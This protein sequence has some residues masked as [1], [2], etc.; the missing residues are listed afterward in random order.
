MLQVASFKLPTQEKEANEF[1]RTHKTDNVS[2]NT[3]MVVCF[4]DDGVYT[5]EAQIADIQELVIA[6]QKARFQ[7]EVALHMMKAELAELHVD[8]HRQKWL[9]L[10]NNIKDLERQMDMHEMKRDFALGRI[11]ELEARLTK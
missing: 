6:N 1:L 9:E 2:F 4:Y 10:T 3:D 11:E 8:L 5:V 7:M